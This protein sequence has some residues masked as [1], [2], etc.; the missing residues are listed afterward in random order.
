MEPVESVTKTP[1]LQPCY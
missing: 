1:I